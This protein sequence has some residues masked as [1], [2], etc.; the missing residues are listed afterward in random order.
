METVR[1][2]FTW[3]AADAN[4]TDSVP[5]DER[6]LPIGTLEDAARVAMAAH[7]G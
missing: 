4:A 7:P 1:R 6:L 2:I 3:F 5:G